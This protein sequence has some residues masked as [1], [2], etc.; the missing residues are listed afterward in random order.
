M[1][2]QSSR[3]AFVIL[4]IGFSSGIGLNSPYSGSVSSIPDTPFGDYDMAI[5]ITG[6]AGFIGS[7][8][9]LRL[10][11]QNQQVVILDNFDDYYDPTIKRGNIAALSGNFSL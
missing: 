2:T 8:L 6:G 1:R 4:E 9:A 5:L 10:L 3:P 7:Q 11:R